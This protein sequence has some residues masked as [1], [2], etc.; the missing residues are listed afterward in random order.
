M[1][2]SR[3]RPPDLTISLPERLAAFLAE[4]QL[5]AATCQV[6]LSGGCD[7][8]SLLHLLLRLRLPGGVA[9]VH[10]HHGLSPNADAWA[11][12]CQDLC[13]Q[14]AVPLQVL[15]VQ[16]SSAGEGLEAAARQARYAAIAQ[17]L[18]PGAPLLLAQH[19]GDQAE[20]LL[21]NLLRG[22]GVQGLAAM[23]PD[24]CQYGLRLLRPL[25]DVSRREL[26]TYATAQGLTW[27]EDESNSDSRFSRNFLRREVLPLLA[28][29]FPATEHILA[30]T[31]AHC[32]EAAD[33]LDELAAS[34]WQL[35]AQGE[36]AAS[37]TGLRTLSGA[38]LKNLLRWRLRTL[39]WQVPGTRR[40][41]EF[42]RQIQGAAADRHPQLQLPQG[43]MHM[44]RGSLRWLPHGQA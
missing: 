18:P 2:V 23:R 29:R 5:G 7:S 33:L 9:A 32:A 42:C 40:L 20:T 13:A 17:H 30:Q 36:A 27:V 19:R 15:H 4:R 41:D 43:C 10:V 28:E 11:A 16:V 37:V 21:F 35:V 14:W 25:L 22:S 6:A 26:E 31:A 44:G 8:V 34:D 24:R 12:F 38:R 1:A 39:G 3:N